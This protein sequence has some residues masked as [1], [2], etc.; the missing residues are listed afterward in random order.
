[1]TDE[2]DQFDFACWEC[3]TAWF[4]PNLVEIEVHAKL[5]YVL[6]KIEKRLSYFSGNLFIGSF[7]FLVTKHNTNDIAFK[8]VVYL[9]IF[10]VLPFNVFFLPFFHL[11]EP[12]IYIWDSW[13][14]EMIRSHLCTVSNQTTVVVSNQDYQQKLREHWLVKILWFGKRD[15][16]AQFLIIRLCYWTKVLA[17]LDN[18]QHEQLCSWQWTRKAEYICNLLSEKH[19]EIDNLWQAPLSKHTAFVVF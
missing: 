15:P 11:H 18:K 7:R 10:L 17:E 6:L 9:T 13:S 3:T 1:M 19:C 2:Y 16:I 4:K 12:V 5:S 8:L 14:Q